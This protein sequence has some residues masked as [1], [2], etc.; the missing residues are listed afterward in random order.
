MN[1]IEKPEVETKIQCEIYTRV[2]GYFRPV[3]QFNK[4][5]QEEY[6]DRKTLEVPIVDYRASTRSF[7]TI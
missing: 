6:F 4:G 2:V 7:S 3:Q 1:H 5:K